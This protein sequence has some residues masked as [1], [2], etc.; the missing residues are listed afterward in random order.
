MTPTP[1]VE[2]GDVVELDEDDGGEDDEGGGDDEADV[3][4]RQKL[5]KLVGATLHRRQR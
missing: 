2:L 1:K 3:R 5:L 4:Q